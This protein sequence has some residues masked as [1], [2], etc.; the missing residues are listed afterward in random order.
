MT[1]CCSLN[2]SVHQHIIAREVDGQT[3]HAIATFVINPQILIGTAL[4]RDYHLEIRFVSRTL[5]LERESSCRNVDVYRS[6]QSSGE[7]VLIPFDGLDC[8]DTRRL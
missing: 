2:A 7:R 4:L 6:T 3:Y 1:P 8:P 5:R